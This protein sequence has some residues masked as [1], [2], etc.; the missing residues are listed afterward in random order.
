MVTGQSRKKHII[1]IVSLLLIALLS[2]G[3]VHS[4]EPGKLLGPTE[5]VIPDWFKTSFLDFRDDAEEASDE[6]RHLLIY[7]HI[8]GCPYCQ[9]M[10]DDNFRSDENSA[11]IQASFDSIELNMH[12]SRE[13][14][15]DENNTLT[16]SHLVK[17]LE[18]RFTPTILFMDAHNRIVMRVNGYRSPRE[19]KHVLNYVKEKA[20]LHTKFTDYRDA[21]LTDAVY[22]L[23]DHPIYQDS[24]DLKQLVDTNKPVAIL[25]EDSQCD[26]CA[27]FHKTVFGIDTIQRVLSEY[28]VVRL[29]AKSKNLII[30]DLGNR[31][32][33]GEWLTRLEISYR[34][35]LLLFNE[36]KHRETS[37]GL[38]KSFHFEQLLSYVAGRHYDK[39]TSWSQYMTHRLEQL[40]ESGETVDVWK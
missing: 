3:S 31:V 26:A 21:H 4:Q 33:P 12:G 18:V 25:F 14:V 6:N 8:H 32:T 9:K 22:T 5:V 20:Y 36:G 1:T 2:V 34:P 35:A 24:Q 13:V 17:A 23:K 28:T 38:L 16:E 30:D 39:F 27:D 37:A 7:F 15:F 11:F 19:F 10:L 29:D 40:L